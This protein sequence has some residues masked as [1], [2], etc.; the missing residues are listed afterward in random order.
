MCANSYTLNHG[1]SDNYSYV[2]VTHVICWFGHNKPIIV[3][4]IG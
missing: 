4:T 3:D 2:F 1:K